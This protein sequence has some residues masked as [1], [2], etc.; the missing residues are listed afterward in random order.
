M[1]RVRTTFTFRKHVFTLT[2]NLPVNQTIKRF[3]TD[4]NVKAG[5]GSRVKKETSARLLLLFDK[6]NFFDTAN[7][8]RR[9]DG[10]NS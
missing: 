7:A 5:N 2:I 3:H 6:R 9:W 1:Q 8:I 4:N 10:K